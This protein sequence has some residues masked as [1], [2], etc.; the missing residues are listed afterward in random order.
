MVYL[1]VKHKVADYDKWRE[2]FDAALETRKSGGEKSFKVFRTVD[3]PN[4]VIVLAE[5]DSVERAK[6]FI[7]SDELK[8]KMK[9][10]GV[11]GEPSINFLEDVTG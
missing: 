1:R 11:L 3:D 2:G 4:D 8:E 9:E 7:S 5:W 10:A 6:V